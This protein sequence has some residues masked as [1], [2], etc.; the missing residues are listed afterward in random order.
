MGEGKPLA[1]STP[2]HPNPVFSKGIT[3]KFILHTNCFIEFC[4]LLRINA[5]MVGS[6]VL[7]AY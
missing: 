5:T 3:A 6:V 4:A 2:L 1:S 7:H